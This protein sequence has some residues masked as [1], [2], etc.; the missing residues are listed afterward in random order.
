MLRPQQMS[1][2]PAV[3][4]P[5]LEGYPCPRARTWAT[6]PQETTGPRA[7]SGTLE[8]QGRRLHAWAGQPGLGQFCQAAR[9]IPSGLP[10]SS[11]PRGLGLSPCPLGSGAHPEAE[12]ALRPCSA[13]GKGQQGGREPV[14]QP[15]PLHRPQKPVRPPPPQRAVWP[16]PSARERGSDPGPLSCPHRSPGP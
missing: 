12:A 7:P 5:W 8:I 15:G 10:S 6:L 11:L 3:G 4:A 14:H 9:L 13:L 2:E 1:P 16:G